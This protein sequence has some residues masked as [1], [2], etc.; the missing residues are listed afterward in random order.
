MS[1]HSLMK[2]R[3]AHSGGPFMASGAT[4]VVNWNQLMLDMAADA[5]RGPKFQAV[6]PGQYGAL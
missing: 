3:E 4:M 1:K 5:R 2:T 6:R